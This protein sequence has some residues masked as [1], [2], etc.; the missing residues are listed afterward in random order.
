VKGKILKYQEKSLIAIEL[1]PGKSLPPLPVLLLS[2]YNRQEKPF[3]R[4]V[5]KYR[6]QR[7]EK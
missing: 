2:P 1:S 3:C 5:P 4:K 6:K 7:G